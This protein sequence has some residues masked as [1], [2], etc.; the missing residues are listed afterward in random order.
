ARHRRVVRV[1]GFSRVAQPRPDRV[2][3]PATGGKTPVQYCGASDCT[4]SAAS[5]HSQQTRRNNPMTEQTSLWK[6]FANM[7]SL[8]GH[9]IVITRSEGSTVDDRDG[10][11]D[12]DARGS[13][14]YCNVGHGRTEIADAAAKQ[15]REL[16]AWH[17]FE[18][19]S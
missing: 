7:G 8:A 5:A 6:P 16:A 19:F 17:M 14:W 12:S 4:R 9:E 15:M 13:V 11:A 3:S 18:F 10:R 2:S 1:R